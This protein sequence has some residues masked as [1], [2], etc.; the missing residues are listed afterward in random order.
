M[1]HELSGTAT[2]GLPSRWLFPWKYWYARE[3]P[4]KWVLLQLKYQK[5]ED[6]IEQAAL[7]NGLCG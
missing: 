7:T 4:R 3:A 2:S 6:G 5:S 1:L